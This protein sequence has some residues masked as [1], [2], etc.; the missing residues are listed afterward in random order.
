MIGPMWQW[1]TALCVAW[2]LV[3]MG[4]GRAEASGRTTPASSRETKADDM[5]LPA[6]F[7]RY[8]GD[9]DAMVKRGNIRALVMTNPIGFFYDNGQPM[10]I[11]T[12]ANMLELPCWVAM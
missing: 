8:T 6:P 11:I 12:V 2:L 4:T 1:R 3:W 7:G 9:L 10:G 5:S